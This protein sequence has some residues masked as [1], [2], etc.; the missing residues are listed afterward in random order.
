MYT[1]LFSSCF[2]NNSY[3]HKHCNIR[4][5]S[6]K[7]LTVMIKRILRK[8]YLN[9]VCTVYCVNMSPKIGVF[10]DYIISLGLKFVRSFSVGVDARRRQTQNTNNTVLCAAEVR[11]FINCLTPSG[12]MKNAI[13]YNVSI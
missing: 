5:T 4:R 11:G 13:H 3:S 10:C 9:N 8:T 7:G 12:G 1:V 6:Y 2:I